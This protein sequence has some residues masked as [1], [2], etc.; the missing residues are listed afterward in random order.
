[1]GLSTNDTLANRYF[2]GPLFASIGSQLKC[3]Q[4]PKCQC[5]TIDS[6]VLFGPLNFE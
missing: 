2:H 4:L 1:M 3:W 6:I 5:C